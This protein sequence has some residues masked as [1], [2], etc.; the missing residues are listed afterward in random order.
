M[1]HRPRNKDDSKFLGW[2][3]RLYHSNAVI[4][5][6]LNLMLSFAESS[7]VNV[8]FGNW[9]LGSSLHHLQWT[10]LKPIKE[11]KSRLIAALTSSPSH[12]TVS[13]ELDS[14]FI[15]SPAHVDICLIAKIYIFTK[16]QPKDTH[17]KS[18]YSSTNQS[19]TVDATLYRRVHITL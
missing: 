7:N 11:N 5:L 10:L 13:Q 17:A 1:N 4:T 9:H 3:N 15:P 12:F 16:Q 19:I 8:L 14:P 6:S 2:W 18:S